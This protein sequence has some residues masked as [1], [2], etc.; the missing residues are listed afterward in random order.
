MGTSIDEALS[1]FEDCRE[2]GREG[3]GEG[4]VGVVEGRR[5]AYKLA[6]RRTGDGT[7]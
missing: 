2:M 3:E 6:E 1:S 7:Q 4:I 5:W